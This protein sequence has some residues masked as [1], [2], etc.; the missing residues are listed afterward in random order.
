MLPNTANSDLSS[1]FCCNCCCDTQ[2]SS[3]PVISSNKQVW[4]H[5]TTKIHANSIPT[6]PGQIANLSH[7]HTG[8]LPDTRIPDILIDCKHSGYTRSLVQR[9]QWLRWLVE[10]VWT[11]ETC[12]ANRRV[13]YHHTLHEF[14]PWFVCVCVERYPY[15][16]HGWCLFRLLY[17][18]VAGII[19]MFY[20]YSFSWI[21]L[22]KISSTGIKF[23]WILSFLW[24]FWHLLNILTLLCEYKF[25]KTS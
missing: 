19:I 13:T 25:W 18:L 22:G 23:H 20:M 4:K 21:W 14:L 9:C 3:I 15:V 5:S 16:P 17:S 2:G 8:S 6:S 12:F 10:D 24:R 1:K 11:Y 7:L